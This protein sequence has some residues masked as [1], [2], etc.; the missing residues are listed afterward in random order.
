MR[1]RFAETPEVAERVRELALRHDE[2]GGIWLLYNEQEQLA[3]VV[4][5]ADRVVPPDPFVPDFAS[6][7][8][9][10]SMPPLG[11]VFADQP[12]IKTFDRTHWTLTTWF[13]F[14]LGD[15]GEPSLWPNSPPFPEPYPGDG[16]CEVS[17]GENGDNSPDCPA[18][19]GDGVAQEGEDTV[20]CPGDV[21]P[22]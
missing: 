19:C 14:V 22:F 7:G 15:H 13:P 21:R 9:L 5:Y 11:D 8:M 3:T 20:N 1:E 2:H 6:L 18:T 4:Y 12:W 17:R 10:A 16:V